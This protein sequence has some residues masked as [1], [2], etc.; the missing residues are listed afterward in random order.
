MEAYHFGAR[1]QRQFIKFMEKS[2]PGLSPFNTYK[3]IHPG[4]AN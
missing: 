3:A 1:L 2:K 4:R